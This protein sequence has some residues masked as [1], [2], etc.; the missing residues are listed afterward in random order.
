MKPCVTAELRPFAAMLTACPPNYFG[1]DAECSHSFS[2]SREYLP[3]L[4]RAEPEDSTLERSRSCAR[5]WISAWLCKLEAAPQDARDIT[6]GKTFLR[7][8]IW[9]MAA[10]A[11]PDAHPACRPTFDHES[12]AHWRWQ[13]T[14]ESNCSNVDSWMLPDFCDGRDDVLNSGSAASFLR[15]GEE[16][17][18]TPLLEHAIASAS[19]SWISTYASVWWAGQLAQRVA[20]KSA[21]PCTRRHATRLPLIRTPAAPSGHVHSAQQAPFTVAIH[22]R[23]GDACMRWATRMGDSALKAKDGG[24]PCYPAALYVNATLRLTGVYAV[25][26]PVQVLLASDDAGAASELAV[27]LALHPVVTSILY[28]EYNRSSV[29]G[30]TDINLKRQVDRGTV[31]IEDR[32]RRGD[33]TLDRALVISSLHAELQLLSRADALVGTSLSYVTRLLFLLIVGHRG[34]IPP[35]VFLDAPLG[36][37]LGPAGRLKP[38]APCA[39]VISSDSSSA[40]RTDAVSSPRRLASSSAAA[41]F[42]SSVAGVGGSAFVSSCQQVTLHPSFVNRAHAADAKAVNSL[43]REYLWHVKTES[44]LAHAALKACVVGKTFGCVNRSSGSPSFWVQDGCRARVACNGVLAAMSPLCGDKVNPRRHVECACDNRRDELEDVVNATAGLDEAS[45]W[46]AQQQATSGSNDPGEVPSFTPSQRLT[47]VP[48]A[49]CKTVTGIP[50]GYGAFLASAV[51]FA[52]DV[53]LTGQIPVL[54]LPPWLPPA[55]ACR[56]VRANMEPGASNATSVALNLLLS[57]RQ[58]CNGHSLPCFTDSRHRCGG[59]SSKVPV[60]G[61]FAER[62]LLRPNQPIATAPFWRVASYTA[63][64]LQPNEGFERL[65]LRPSLHAPGSTSPRLAVHLRYGDSCSAFEQARTARRCGPVREYVQ[66]ALRLHEIYGFRSVVISSDSAR[67]Q[68]QFE[69]L[70]NRRTPVFTSGARAE[71]LGDLWQD[72]G[73]VFEQHSS[74]ILRDAAI[75]TDSANITNDSRSHLA[76]SAQHQAH[77]IHK[78]CAEWS[79]FSDFLID[80]HTLA[81]C[82]AFVGTFTSNFGRLVFALMVARKGRTPPFVSLDNSTWCNNAKSTW[83]VSL[84]GAFPCRVDAVGDAAGEDSTMLH[85]VGK[86]G[87]ARMAVP[88]R[89]P[90]HSNTITS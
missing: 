59:L 38:S 82:D 32:L 70:W 11:T 69:A 51:S 52:W 50:H 44:T 34:V 33:P 17:L 13:P 24:R 53:E 71:G 60:A 16:L 81:A 61:T 30:P 1:K 72:N 90:G 83:G 2:K 54:K 68:R 10:T 79:R 78:A 8:L 87:H 22:M 9:T 73:K 85:E 36:W 20:I 6:V 74:A 15:E 27:Q 49:R 12:L 39:S 35:F 40:S 76:S 14:A 31:Y 65:L 43:G 42:A 75:V 37:V 64:L 46:Q 7:R 19:A 67:A 55:Q 84:Y 56:T 18:R 3:Q 29:G 5:T 28:Y 26:R 25:G 58:E 80:M 23:R 21:G 41:F 66:A 4:R 86:D 77:A 89:R 57:G 48:D 45:W 88:I 62:F 47:T 63:A